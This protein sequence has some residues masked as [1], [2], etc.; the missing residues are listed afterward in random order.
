ML[1]AQPGLIGLMRLDRT[2]VFNALRQAGAL[3]QMPGRV[4][5]SARPAARQGK[6]DQRP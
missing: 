2:E 5:V 3:Q 4:L 6:V 1:L